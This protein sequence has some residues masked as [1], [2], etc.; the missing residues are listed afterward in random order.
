MPRSTSFGATTNIQI[1][2]H[3][4]KAP[5]AKPH[6]AINIAAPVMPVAKWGNRAVLT[7]IITATSIRVWRTLRLAAK[8]AKMLPITPATPYS[9]SSEP[10]VGPSKP[11]FCLKKGAT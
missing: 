11:A 1:L 8:P 4:G 5:K 3:A 9:N 7:P 10:I 2:A 6:S